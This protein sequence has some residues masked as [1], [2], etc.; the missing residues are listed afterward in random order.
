MIV[1]E[2]LKRNMHLALGWNP[3][4]GCLPWLSACGERLTPGKAIQ[5]AESQPFTE[6]PEAGS[7][8]IKRKMS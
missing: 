6:H 4:T 2:V 5:V 8:P 7:I 1:E 3:V